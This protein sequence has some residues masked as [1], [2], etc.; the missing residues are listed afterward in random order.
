MKDRIISGAVVSLLALILG[1]SIALAHNGIEH[2]MGTVSAITQTSITVD[3]VKHATVTVVF[4]SSTQF[5]HNDAA[6]SWKDLKAG[7]RVVVNA[8]PDSDKKL[9]AVSVRWGAAATAHAD[10]G[11]H[12]E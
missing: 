4:D 11:E 3:T 9:V 8:K 1:A 7:D 12:K 5:S 6:A 10:H 2:V